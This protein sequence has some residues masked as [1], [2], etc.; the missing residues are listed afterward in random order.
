MVNAP[1]RH[2]GTTL[3]WNKIELRKGNGALTHVV[4]KGSKK[5]SSKIAAIQASSQSSSSFLES[6]IQF[7]IL[8]CTKTNLDF[9]IGI[10]IRLLCS[11][12]NISPS[13]FGFNPNRKYNKSKLEYVHD[14]YE[15]I[16]S[17]MSWTYRRLC[18][19]LGRPNLQQMALRSYSVFTRQCDIEQLR[20]EHQF[21]SSGRSCTTPV[22]QIPFL[23]KM[24]KYGENIRRDRLENWKPTMNKFHQYLQNYPTITARKKFILAATNRLTIEEQKARGFKSNDLCRLCNVEKESV[25]HVLAHKNDIG[26]L[27]A[28][29]YEENE[30]YPIVNEDGMV[31][32]SAGM[33]AFLADCLDLRTL[34]LQRD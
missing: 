4:E 32:T 17:R 12:A 13:F 18:L 14:L 30:L 20:K 5:D 6:R 27:I 19:I 23:R 21:L 3:Q 22:D 7:A 8:F 24:R 29:N 34:N 1:G 25:S 9:L 11:L 2:V 10:H 26:Y 31:E 28:Q 33:A 16:E 15:E